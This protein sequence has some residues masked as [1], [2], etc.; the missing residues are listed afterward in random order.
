MPDLGIG[1]TAAA[2]GGGDLL[3]GLFGGGA[4]AA[5]AAG[6]ADLGASAAAPLAFDA[7]AGSG[8]LDFLGAS[9]AP[10]GFSGAPSAGFLGSA[11]G[12]PVGDSAGMGAGIFGTS[13]ANP[14][15]DLTGGLNFGGAS[16]AAGGAGGGIFDTAAGGAGGGISTGE[17][18]GN[19]ASAPYDL[20]GAG[21]T[22]A[23][24]PGDPLSALTSQIGKNPLGLAAG[25]GGL[26]YA[27]SNA[28]KQPQSVQQ[29]QTL[30]AGDTAAAGQFTTAGQT[31]QSY[32]PQGALPPGQQAQLEQATRAEKAKIVQSY[33]SQGLPADPAK[34]TA[35]A[36]D[37]NAVDERALATKG[38]LEGQDFQAGQQLINAGIQ[39][40]GMAN[41]LYTQLQQIDQTNT[42]AI[43]AAIARMAA[44]LSG[45]LKI[46][47]GSG[48][49]T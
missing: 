27:I 32:L 35:L 39:E 43:G 21:T 36:Q 34:N 38:T 41:A 17:T 6:A 26:A 23:A 42:T 18:I 14:V 31:M 13:G 37:L 10:G 4:D 19:M 45:N 20:G 24:G 16:P 2:L 11:S 46:N 30:A 25:A 28:N 7:T 15:G 12:A 33:A 40:S 5:G 47:I 29:L 44:A 8:P 48:A 1:E 49:T 22:A 3:A 9:A